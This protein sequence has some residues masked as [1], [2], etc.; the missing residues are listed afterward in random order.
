MYNKKSYTFSFLLIL[1]FFMLSSSSC[2][3]INKKNNDIKSTK[4]VSIK[5]GKKYNI[6]DIVDSYKNVSVYYNGPE[7]NKSF[8]QSY[9]SD[10]YYYGYKWQCVEFIKRFYY[11]VYKHKMPDAY[12]NAKDYFNENVP[13]GWINKSRNML[14]YKNGEAESPK[15]DDLLVF[16]DT[17]FGHVAIIT[18]IESDKIHVV[19]QNV[20][21]KSR[22]TYSL[23]KVKGKYYV[24][25]SR[26]PAGWLRIKQ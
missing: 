9:S 18:K 4:A 15:L 26:K 20:Y 8:G 16:T 1:L 23:K 2:L 5:N 6:G 12:G 24:G 14:Q 17:K 19:Q 3:T 13:Q 22:D 21:G 11:V 7:Y 10:G 25:T